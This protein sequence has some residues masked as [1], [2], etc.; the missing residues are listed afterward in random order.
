MAH[1]AQ[2]PDMQARRAGHGALPV[3]L[4]F[5]AALALA[6]FAIGYLAWSGPQRL[7]NNAIE[8]K[9]PKA[10][11]PTPMPNPQPIPAPL[12]RPG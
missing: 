1:S 4:F 6:M 12:P 8:L 2:R 9:L 11:T 3:V 5:V 7:A 10:P